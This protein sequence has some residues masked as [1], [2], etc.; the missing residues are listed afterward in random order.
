MLIG[1]SSQQAE[2]HVID[3]GL[4]NWYQVG[5]N[6]SHIPYTQY[7]TIT[8]T[9]RYLSVNGH[10]GIEQSR[11]DD[12]ESL[13]YVLIYLLQ[14]KLPWQ[15]IQAR[16]QKEKYHRIMV[17]KIEAC[18]TLCVGLPPVFDTFLNYSQNLSFTAEPDYSYI[19]T[20]FREAFE[21]EGY[22][23]DYYFDWSTTTTFC[24]DDDTSSSSSLDA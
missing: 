7:S 2:V 10:R 3:F 6:H 13:A 14:G 19:Y 12:L 18:S 11:R 1:I 8:G 16:T 20:L 23:W 5:T 24:V 21:V 9:A 4:A 17:T 22:V 15:N